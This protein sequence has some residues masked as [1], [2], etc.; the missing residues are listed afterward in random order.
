MIFHSCHILSIVP[1]KSHCTHWTF[2]IKDLN[3][4]STIVHQ[5][6]S[7]KAP[8]GKSNT[9]CYLSLH[10]F[11]AGS[12]PASRRDWPGVWWA[13]SKTGFKFLSHPS[14]FFF[15]LHSCLLHFSCAQLSATIKCFKEKLSKCPTFKGRLPLKVAKQSS[16]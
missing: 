6:A 15:S 5:Y 7:D 14:L 11:I 2:K 12:L 4:S 10:H 8:V 9:V 3:T 13:E 1:C 16:Y